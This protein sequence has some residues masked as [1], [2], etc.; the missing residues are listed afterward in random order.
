[1]SKFRQFL[2]EWLVSLRVMLALVPMAAVVGSACAFFLWSL[3]AVTDVRLLHSWMI[4]FLPIG[5]VVVGF[6]YHWVGRSAEGG[7]TSILDEIHAP[8][9]CGVSRRMAPLILFGTLVTHLFGGSAGREGTAVQ[10]GGS[11]ASGFCRALRLGP[12]EVRT[13]LMGGVAAGF[14]AVFGTPLAGV[15]FAME[16]RT[17]GT[18]RYR[19]V[20]GCILAALVG[21]WTCRA[22]GIGHT[23]YLVA[24]LTG[25]PPM[26]FVKVALAAAGF[27]L[28][29]R[30][31]C[32]FSR[33]LG[34]WLKRLVPFAPMR[35]AL[36]GVL[37]IALFFTTGTPD[38]LGLGVW[39]RDPN[40]LTIRSFFTSS[41][42]LP[43][44]WLW[45]LVFTAITL[46]SGFKGGEVTPL[47][48]IGAAL[49]HALAAAL[50]APLSLFAALGFVSIFAGA[51]KTPLACTVMGMELFGVQYGVFLA[52][53]CGI[54]WRVS[55]GPGL[56]RKRMTSAI[57][58]PA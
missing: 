20:I 40:A 57:S 46:S 47:F 8:G 13:M 31:Y 10:M 15:V 22:W 12:A 41:E 17:A 44:I 21:D 45:K 16:A 58:P 53:A 43:L 5:G 30:F 34:E 19:A 36:G 2:S 35:P 14:G 55:G 11:L 24:S 7:T 54:A 39:A 27:G 3:D 32:D 4:Y 26:L 23:Q 49:G 33:W 25:W 38:Y 18:F 52:L 51:T 48:F 28:V 1:M 29:S 56:Y 9:G 37:V 42:P 6:L 50:G